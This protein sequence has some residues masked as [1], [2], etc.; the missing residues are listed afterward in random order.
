ME[1]PGKGGDSRKETETR[2][3]AVV[4]AEEPSPPWAP[5]LAH[6]PYWASSR[7]LEQGKQGGGPLWEVWHVE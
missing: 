1:Y 3:R 2:H 5:T 6:L 7:A 4:G